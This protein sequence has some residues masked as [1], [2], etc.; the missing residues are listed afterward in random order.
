MTILL[1]PDKFKGSLTAVQVCAAIE[2]GIRMVNSAVEIISTPLADGGE[3]TGDLLV[4]Y[5]QG[6]HIG[7]V[8]RDPLFR[9][10]TSGYGI[11]RDGNVAFIEMAKV[12]GLQLL[13][14]EERNPMFT[15]TFGTGQLIRDAMERGARHIILGI[16]GSATNDAGI[17]MADALGYSFISIDNK[18]LKPMGGSL[19]Q[20]TTIETDKIHPLLSHTK[21]TV[22]CDVDNLLYGGNGAAYI[23]GPQKGATETMVKEL[24]KGLQNFEEIARATFKIE[25]NFPGAGAAGGLGAGAKV[26]LNAN[27]SK[28]FD[29]ISDFTNLEDSIRMSDLIIT[30][31]G[32]IDT[33]TLSGKVVKGVAD[34]AAKHQKPCIAFAGKCDQPETLTASL[35]LLKIISLTDDHTSDSAAMANA[36]SILKKRSQELRKWV[37]KS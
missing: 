22:L 13:N 9:E 11:S 15:T 35:N 34:L 32:K 20:I 8:A 27:L 10:V 29:F 19:T 16:G 4:E 12:S 2:E 17:G 7:I 6:S 1:A 26:F 37:S 23:F 24:D 14:P 21:F 18:K 28:G 36:F 3:G 25:V 5:T 31:E 33:Q 30:G